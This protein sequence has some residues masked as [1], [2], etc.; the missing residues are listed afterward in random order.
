MAKKELA[1]KLEPVEEAVKKTA[2]KAGQ[3][4]GDITR[5]A[6]KKATP[7]V[8]KATRSVQ[9]AGKKATLS[10]QDAGK[11]AAKALSPAVYVQ[12]DDREADCAEVVERA[13]TDYRAAHK[14]A[15]R[16]CKVYIKPQ[17]GVAYYV[18]NGTA[19]KVEL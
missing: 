9:D 3:A 11:K 4:V 18:I 10:V 16:S 17:D 19:G 2:V 15:I 7:A 8:K 13:R 6:V 12:W 5:E 14:D 1:Q